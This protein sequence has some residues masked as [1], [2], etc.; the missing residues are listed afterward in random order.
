MTNLFYKSGQRVV[1]G[2][3]VQYTA[4]H[5]GQVVGI[6]HDAALSGTEILVFSQE[7]GL[8]SVE[9]DDVELVFLARSDP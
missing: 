3:T 9:V 2:D 7:F 4:E 8:I 6:G 5:N 1:I